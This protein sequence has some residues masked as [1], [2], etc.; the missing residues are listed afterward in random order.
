M[1]KSVLA[2]MLELPRV[3]VVEVQLLLAMVRGLRS[4]KVLDV[5]T[6]PIAEAPEFIRLTLPPA[7]TAKSV[8]EPKRAPL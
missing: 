8:Q 2:T 5:E 4:Q 3:V 1:T 6:P 7:M